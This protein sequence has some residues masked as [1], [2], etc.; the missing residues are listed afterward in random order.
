MIAPVSSFEP[1]K[2]GG[3]RFLPAHGLTLM[4][5]TYGW[6]FLGMGGVNS[7][8]LDEGRTVIW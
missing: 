8:A 5:L 7:D 3:T 2:K 1:L 6:R 4:A